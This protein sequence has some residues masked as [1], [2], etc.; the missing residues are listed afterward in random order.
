MNNSQ[1]QQWIRECS[2]IVFFGGTGVSTESGIPDFRGQNGIFSALKKYHREPEVLLSYSYFRMRPDVFF[3]YYRENILVTDAKPN[4]AHYA[5]AAMEAKGILSAVITQNVDGLHQKAGSRRVLELH[6]SIYR[7]YCMKCGKRYDVETILGTE[8]VPFCECGGIIRPDVVMY[9][10]T[11]PEDVFTEAEN[12]I[13]KADMLIVGGT[14]LSVYPAAG[15]LREFRGKHLVL[16]NKSETPYDDRADLVIRE[17]IGEVFA[18]L[19][20]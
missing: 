7:N 11:L 14:S 3:E 20:I 19:E 1:L 2:R 15:L 5:L 17:P 8:G 18:G 4:P 12:E 6:G 16:I 9:E 10:E 13:F